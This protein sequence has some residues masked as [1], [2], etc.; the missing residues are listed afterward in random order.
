M[1]SNASNPF[2]M[3]RIRIQILR[4]SFE[5]F[6]FAFER[7]EFCSTFVSQH[8]SILGSHR[9]GPHFSNQGLRLGPVVEKDKAAFIMHYSK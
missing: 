4:I 2:R 8:A 6:E 9:E 7:F 5:V 3:V 1:H